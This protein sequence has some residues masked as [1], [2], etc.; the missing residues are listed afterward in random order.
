MS[1]VKRYEIW[2]RNFHQQIIGDKTGATAALTMK[3]STKAEEAIHLLE[4]TAGTKVRIIHVVRNP[5]D[6]IATM[7]L[8]NEKVRARY[9]EHKIKV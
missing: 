4:K 8:R 9:G 1:N 6:N 2:V 7:V 3:T 5:F